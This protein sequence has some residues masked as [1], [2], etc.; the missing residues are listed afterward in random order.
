M[1]SF[2]A[3]CGTG[4]VYRNQEVLPGLVDV[5]VGAFDDPETLSPV[6]HI[7]GAE[8]LDWMTTIDQLP[9]IDRYPSPL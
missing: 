6:A 9:V 8:R 1:R 5:Q 7:Q 2:C 3:S 4:L